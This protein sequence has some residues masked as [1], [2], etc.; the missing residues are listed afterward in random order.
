V[1]IRCAQPGLVHD[2]E[3]SRGVGVY[4]RGDCGVI[5]PSHTTHLVLASSLDACRTQASHVAHDYRGGIWCSRWICAHS[6]SVFLFLLKTDVL[7][8]HSIRTKKSQHQN[9]GY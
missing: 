3:S 1:F 5:V 6:Q 7:A 4:Q 8:T 2:P 9:W